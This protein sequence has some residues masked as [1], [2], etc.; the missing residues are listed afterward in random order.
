VTVKLGKVIGNVVATRKAGN[1]EGRKILVVRY[2]N[3][4]LVETGP[5]HACIDT[6]N[7]GAND[8]VM[9]CASSSARLTDLTKGVAT[10]CAIVGIVDAVTSGDDRIYSRH[11]DG[12]RGRDQGP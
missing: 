9:L 8:V 1:M 7:A 4:D 10:D 3:E 12:N 6:V 11:S 5:V 2:L